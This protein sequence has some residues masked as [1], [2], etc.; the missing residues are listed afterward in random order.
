MASKKES[1]EKWR[2]MV[3]LLISGCIF[4]C[5]AQNPVTQK[6]PAKEPTQKV[7]QQEDE[8]ER[9]AWP[10]FEKSRPATASRKTPKYKRRTPKVNVSALNS[11]TLENK[12]IGVTIWRLSRSGKPVR[13]ESNTALAIGDKVFLTIEVPYAGHLYVVDR[14]KY[15]DGSFGDPELIFPDT[16]IREGKNKVEPGVLIRIPD[17]DNYFKLTRSTV[18]HVGESL[19]I[20]VKEKPIP[21]LKIGAEPLKL[22]KALFAEWEKNWYIQIER[23]EMDGGPGQPITEAEIKAR[24]DGERKLTLEDP[25]PQTIYQ[26]MVKKGNPV[27]ISLPLDIAK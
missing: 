22:S 11:G 3:A 10:V 8:G 24:P 12:T 19:T 6:A 7:E 5:M 23:F 27:F 14:E 4:P 13:V 18:D 16:R 17:G 1:S 21:D 9:G 2:A 15:K 20:M 26:V 25:Y